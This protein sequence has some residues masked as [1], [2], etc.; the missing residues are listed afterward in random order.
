[1]EMVVDRE[2]PLGSE[3][4]GGGLGSMGFGDRMVDVGVGVG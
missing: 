4:I 3:S 1:M 2:A